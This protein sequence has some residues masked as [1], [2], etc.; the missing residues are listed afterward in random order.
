MGKGA[1]WLRRGMTVAIGLP[2][3]FVVSMISQNLAGAL[4][5]AGFQALQQVLVPNLATAAFL[6]IVAASVTGLYGGVPVTRFL[7]RLFPLRATGARR[8]GLMVALAVG[9]VAA[10]VFR[11]RSLVD[12]VPYPGGDPG[13]SAIAVVAGLVV[14]WVQVAMALWFYASRQAQRQSPFV[15]YLRR[16]HGFSDRVAYRFLLGSLPAGTS[17]ATLVPVVGGPRDL[18]PFVL[19]FAGFRFRHPLRSMPRTFAAPNAEWQ[20]CVVA[21]MRSAD[22]V[23]VDGSAPSGAMQFEYEQIAA[24]GLGARTVLLVEEGRRADAPLIEGA[25]TLAY[26]RSGWASAPRALIWAGLVALYLWGN[27]TYPI[28]YPLLGMLGMLL[29]LPALLQKSVDR[30]SARALR[31]H[32]ARQVRSLPGHGLGRLL[33]RTALAGALAACGALLVGRLVPDREPLGHDPEPWMQADAWQTVRD[34]QLG[35]TVL[36]VPVPRGFVD[37]SRMV[38]KTR[39][40]SETVAEGMPLRHLAA[41]VPQGYVARVVFEEH[42]R[43]EANMALQTPRA[44]EGKTVDDDTFA[45]MKQEFRAEMSDAPEMDADALEAAKRVGVKF[46][47]MRPLGVFDERSRSISALGLLVTSYQLDGQTFRRE[48]ICAST[49]LRIRGHLLVMTLC[50]DHEGEQ[51]AAWV[52]ALTRRWIEQMSVRN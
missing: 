36:K 27:A 46:E 14:V 35:D 44:W 49:N 52:R 20:Q 37:A 22:A 3:V 32:V 8:W 7:L 2:L 26:R 39:T 42:T 13:P 34:V 17:L 33:G 40:V 28:Q 23:V 21:L 41:F 19:G 31:E 4:V 43:L 25:T 51:D 11:L 30:A 16:F 15:L 38:Q 29:M 6:V 45:A 48:K 18:D 1:Q 5:V 10:G 24:L 9:A 12:L 47:S 50:R